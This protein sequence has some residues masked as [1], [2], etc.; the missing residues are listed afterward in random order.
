MNFSWNA[1]KAGVGLFVIFGLSLGILIYL[2]VSS[3]D[4]DESFSFELLAGAFGFIVAMIVSP[5]LATIVGAI[6]AK[7]FD[8]ESD[9][10]FNGA[11]AG[12][13]GT[14]LMVVVAILFLVAAM[15]SIDDGSSSD[16]SVDDS[17]DSDDDS[18]LLPS[19]ILSIAATKNNMATTTIKKVPATPAIAPLKAASDSSSKSLAMIAPTIV[20]RTGLTIIATIKPKAPASNSNENDSSGSAEDTNK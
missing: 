7:D 13:A 9:A 14:F 18:L 15:E 6:I 20:A 11:I 10:A 19:S 12:V 1:V 17:D 4:P 3:A 5:V 2:L 8:D 16:S